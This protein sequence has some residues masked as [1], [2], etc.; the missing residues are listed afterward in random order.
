M[1]TPLTDTQVAELLAVADG[2]VSYQ[3][4][5]ARTAATVREMSIAKIRR[6]A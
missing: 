6:C 3:S 2:D 4:N 5:Y 1:M